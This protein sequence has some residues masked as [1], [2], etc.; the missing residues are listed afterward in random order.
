MFNLIWHCC[1]ARRNDTKELHNNCA[2]D[3]IDW[4]KRWPYKVGTIVV[5]TVNRYFVLTIALLQN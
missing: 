1:G 2:P 5:N 3:T 4:M